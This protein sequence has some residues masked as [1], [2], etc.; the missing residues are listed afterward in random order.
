MTHTAISPLQQFHQNALEHKLSA[1][2]ILLWQHIY[3][4]A[5]AQNK[6]TNLRLR[7][8]D[9]MAVLSLTRN[10]LQKIRH[11]LINAGLLSVRIDARQQMYYTLMIGGEIVKHNETTNWPNGQRAAEGGR[12]L[13][14][15]NGKS[16]PSKSSSNPYTPKHTANS[17]DILQ[18]NAYRKL[19]DAFC[20]QHDAVGTTGLSIRLQQFL[21]HRKQ[22]GKT[23]TRAGLDALLDKLKNLAASNVRTMVDIIQQSINRGWYGFYPYKPITVVVAHCRGGC[24]QP[25]ANNNP[26]NSKPSRIPKYDT[27]KENLDFLEW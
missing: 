19:I 9:L 25:P 8:A 26:W 6:Y 23:L 17:G 15:H 10:G 21:H 22:Q 27:K 5:Q 11:T 14:R 2:A 4:I 18:N 13:Q 1:G 12:P 16:S 7:T 24:P 3:F 20:T